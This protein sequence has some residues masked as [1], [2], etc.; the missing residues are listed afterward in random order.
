M[1]EDG[2]VEYVRNGEHVD[3]MSMREFTDWCM[4]L[5]VKVLEDITHILDEERK[6]QK[7]RLK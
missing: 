2:G 5:P 6:I 4:H 7:A 1:N 3:D